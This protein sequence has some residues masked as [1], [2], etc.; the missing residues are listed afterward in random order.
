[1]NEQILGTGSE[2]LTGVI[3]RLDPE[4]LAFFGP[5]HLWGGTPAHG[6]SGDCRDYLWDCPD[7]CVWEAL[8]TVFE[9]FGLMAEQLKATVIVMMVGSFLIGIVLGSV[10]TVCNLIYE[11][12]KR[13]RK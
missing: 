3:R 6:C 9:H 11:K 5:G 7:V 12:L 4:A 13:P 10:L 8:V 1:M 2:R